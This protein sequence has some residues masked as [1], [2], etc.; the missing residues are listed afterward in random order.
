MANTILLSVRPEYAQKIL[1]GTKKVELRRARPRLEPG[2]R[3]LVYVSSPQKAVVGSFQVEKIVEE[4][5]PALWEMVETKAGISPEEFYNY[6]EGVST[7]VGI[8]FKEIRPFN[9]PVALGLLR[10]K[11]SSWRPPQS[12]RYM[13]NT[14]YELVRE[15]GRG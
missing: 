6:Y 11:W 9:Q 14:E 12:Y 3:V 7:G 1:A 2:D 15:L 13:S 10:K 5:L 4:P 8:F